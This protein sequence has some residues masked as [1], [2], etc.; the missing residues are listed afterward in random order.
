MNIKNK[1]LG[2]LVSITKRFLS[3]LKRCVVDSI[4]IAKHIVQSIRDFLPD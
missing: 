4:C 3:Q 2:P 1:V